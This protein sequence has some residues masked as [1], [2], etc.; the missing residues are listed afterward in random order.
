MC[1]IIDEER[2]FNRI[3]QGLQ[4]GQWIFC[5][6]F[7]CWGTWDSAGC[8][9]RAHMTSEIRYEAAGNWGG[10]NTQKE[11]NFVHLVIRPP[12]SQ[13]LLHTKVEGFLECACALL[14]DMMS[15]VYIEA[16]DWRPETERRRRDPSKK[17]W[18]AFLL[19]SVVYCPFT[20]SC[21]KIDWIIKCLLQTNSFGMW[22][23]ISIE[24]FLQIIRKNVIQHF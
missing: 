7:I 23:D 3:K 4:L 8:L 13:S 14:L 11:L 17:Q 24:D 22:Y 1:C 2:A 10:C 5:L 20:A 16:D 12:P 21:Y 15:Q 19:H 9:W 18:I 6:S